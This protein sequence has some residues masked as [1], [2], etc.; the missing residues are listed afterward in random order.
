MK[1]SAEAV[2]ALLRRR[3]QAGVTQ[4][5][6]LSAVGTMRLGAR[7]WELRAAGHD[8]ET[9]MVTMPSGACVAR[10]TIREQPEQMGFVL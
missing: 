6:A 4:L 5:D 9:K 2:L 7:V 1:P 10:Y 8:I 3:G